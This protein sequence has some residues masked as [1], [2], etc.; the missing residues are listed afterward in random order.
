MLTELYATW[1]ISVV[2]EGANEAEKGHVQ[3]L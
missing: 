1:S 3:S 2:S